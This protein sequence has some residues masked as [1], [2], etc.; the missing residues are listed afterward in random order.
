M[1]E[2]NSESSTHCSKYFQQSHRNKKIIK[3]GGKDSLISE[4]FILNIWLDYF[5]LYIRYFNEVGILTISSLFIVKAVLKHFLFILGIKLFVILI[6][7][8]LKE[9]ITF[10]L[11]IR[12]ITWTS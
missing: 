4:K 1:L 7:Q 12:G 5:N 8:L 11:L 9:I 3:L 6:H 2:S 10:I